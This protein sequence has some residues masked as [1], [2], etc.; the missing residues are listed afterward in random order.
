MKF[1]VHKASVRDVEAELL[2]KYSCFL[3]RS[4]DGELAVS[5]GGSAMVHPGCASPPGR[6]GARLC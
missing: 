5:G 2:S 4:E 6:A 1:F 3:G